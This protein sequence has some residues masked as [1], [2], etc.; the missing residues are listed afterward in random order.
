MNNGYKSWYI[1]GKHLKCSSDNEF[2]RI[3]KMK[4]FL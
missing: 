3:M 1:N 2:I 4:E